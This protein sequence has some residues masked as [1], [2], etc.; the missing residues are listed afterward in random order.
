MQK[1]QKDLSW[2]VKFNWGALHN[3]FKKNIKKE[4]KLPLLRRLKY[5]LSENPF[6]GRSIGGKEFGFYVIDIL[7]HPVIYYPYEKEKIILVYRFDK[8][9]IDINDLL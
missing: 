6:K 4:D 8:R 2:K 1:K 9:R 7:N 5:E 3:D